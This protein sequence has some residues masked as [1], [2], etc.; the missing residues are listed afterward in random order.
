MGK[1]EKLPKINPDEPKDN[2]EY[3]EAVSQKSSSFDKAF[4]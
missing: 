3:I 4:K 1:F 2:I